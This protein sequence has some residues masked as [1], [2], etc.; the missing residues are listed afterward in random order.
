MKW[1]LTEDEINQAVKAWVD[2]DYS[3]RSIRLDRGHWEDVASVI[4]QAQLRKVYQR[5]EASGHLHETSDSTINF[6]FMAFSLDRAAWD[7]LNEE[8]G[9]DGKC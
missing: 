3:V 7:A 6:A 2:E 5:L 4:A 9:E 1:L 8:A